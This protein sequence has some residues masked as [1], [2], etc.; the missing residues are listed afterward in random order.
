MSRGIYFGVTSG[1]CLPKGLAAS[2]SQTPFEVTL[3]RAL[4]LSESI[5]LRNLS[6]E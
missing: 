2:N 5:I 1:C 3:A 4:L 6:L